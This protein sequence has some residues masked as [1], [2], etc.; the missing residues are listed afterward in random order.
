MRQDTIVRV[1]SAE[2]VDESLE[3]WREQLRRG[4]LDLAILLAVERK[5][6]YGLEIIRH[7][8]E[9]TD[10]V[11]TEGTIYPILARL[12]RN[13]VIEAEWIADESPHPRKYYRLSH[14]GR[15]TLAEMVGQWERFR[16]KIDRLVKEAEGVTDET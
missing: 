11:V 5:P 8:Q 14:L 9:S 2:H 15:K 1:R 3:K 10:L 13:G 12:T 4:G 7:L 16:Q 6:R